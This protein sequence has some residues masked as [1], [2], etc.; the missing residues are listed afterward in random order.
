MEE[1]MEEVE[2]GI[3]VEEQLITDV[4]FANDKAMVGSTAMGLQIIMNKLNKT[5]RKYSM[6]INIKRQRL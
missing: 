4:R 3:K 5:S 2:E 6:K 1:A